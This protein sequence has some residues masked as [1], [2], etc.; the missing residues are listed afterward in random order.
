MPESS[1]YKILLLASILASSSF[2]VKAD[3]KSVDEVNVYSS[4]Q[5]HLIRPL[6]D[7]FSDKTGIRVNLVTGNGGALITRLAAEGKNSPADVFITTDVAYLE[8]AK[9]KRLTQ[10]ISSTLLRQSVP[11][12]YR[13][14]DNHWFGLS[15]RARAIFAQRGKLNDSDNLS[16]ESLA[17]PRWRKRLCIRSSA[18]VYNQSLVASMIIA[19]GEAKTGEW[20]KNLVANFARPPS[21]ND[22]DQIMAVA[23]G[24]C[25]VAV[26]N[27]YYLAV[28]LKTGSEEQKEAA[29]KVAIHWPNQRDRGAHI[30]LSGAFVT[31]HA[32]HRQHAILLIESLL[33]AEMQ[34]MY[35]NLNYEYPVRNDLPLN[36]LL[37]SWGDFKRE[38][39]PFSELGGLNARATRLMDIGGWR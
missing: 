11:A 3:E 34:S 1:L 30:N 32:P 24:R 29:Q 27:S 5:E 16:Y 28:M 35:M 21:G 12:N 9:E 39:A 23:G 8:R 2:L 25:D 22:R 26:A 36:E 6:L 17:D 37:S 18:N 15:L 4:R 13:D 19:R 20:I 7:K 31:K 14:A 38:R 10:A 33:S